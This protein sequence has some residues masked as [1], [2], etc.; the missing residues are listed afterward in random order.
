MK[1]LLLSLLPRREDWTPK[2]VVLTALGAAWWALLLSDY[3]VLAG[4][5]T[6]Y[7]YPPQY[8]ANNIVF[9]S[10]CCSYWIGAGRQVS[11]HTGPLNSVR[12]PWTLHMR[13]K[14]KGNSKRCSRASPVEQGIIEDDR[15][16]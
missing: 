16:E 3:G 11:F 13:D 1:R 7:Y 6:T 4:R 9:E 10:V 5:S 12:C 2:V 15:G 14:W 8:T